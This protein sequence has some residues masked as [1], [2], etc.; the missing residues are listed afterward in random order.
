MRAVCIPH[1]FNQAFVNVTGKC[2]KTPHT[3]KREFHNEVEVNAFFQR[4]K[5]RRRQMI[6]RKCTTKWQK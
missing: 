6:D 4:S 3:Q 1:T 2:I 5:Q